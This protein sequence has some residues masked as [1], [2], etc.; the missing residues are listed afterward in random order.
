MEEKILFW[1]FSF[2]ISFIPAR[3]Y[4]F[5]NLPSP[6]VLWI[7]NVRER[8]PTQKKK[9][10]LLL[11]VNIFHTLFL[12]LTLNR[13][14]FTWFILKRQTFLKIRSGNKIYSQIAF[15]LIPS[16]RYGWISEKFLRR[17]LLQTLVV[18]RKM[19]LTVKMTCCVYICL[20]TDFSC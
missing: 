14:T 8:K 4:L 9:V 1:Q 10:S 2:V 5:S 12:L 13:Q 3:D 19:Q 16:Q 18:A 7:V 15:E 11:T 6:A 17:K 20:F